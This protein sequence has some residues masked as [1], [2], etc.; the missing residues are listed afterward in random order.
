MSQQLQQD[1]IDKMM[2]FGTTPVSIPFQS[3]AT[4]KKDESAPVFRQYQQ[5]YPI[6]YYEQKTPNY[7]GI[8]TTVEKWNPKTS[9]WEYYTSFQKLYY[10]NGNPV[11]L[12]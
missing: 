7:F 11:G 12:Y 8:L 3:T 4:A 6:Q 5:C 2:G 10:P 1:D 9:K